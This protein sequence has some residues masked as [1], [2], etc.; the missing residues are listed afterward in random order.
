MFLCLE[1]RDIGL[2]LVKAMCGWGEA[3]MGRTRE[4]VLGSVRRRWQ[5]PLQPLGIQHSL[6]SCSHH[7]ILGLVLSHHCPLRGCGWPVAGQVQLK[8]APQTLDALGFQSQDFI[9]LGHKIF[10]I[11]RKETKDKWSFWFCWT[12]VRIC[13]SSPFSCREFSEPLGPFFS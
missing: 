6:L 3:N 12:S 10:K 11:L 4:W 5:R 2:G 1:L 9:Q 8:L 7:L 13:F